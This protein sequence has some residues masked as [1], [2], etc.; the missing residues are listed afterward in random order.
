MF[1]PEQLRLKKTENK[2]GNPLSQ[3]KN[4]QGKTKITPLPKIEIAH[5]PPHL[6]V[7]QNTPP[8]HHRTV[9]QRPTTTPNHH[10]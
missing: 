6:T 9:T 7:N 1:I 2:Q 4:N 3:T 5:E 8:L 10:F